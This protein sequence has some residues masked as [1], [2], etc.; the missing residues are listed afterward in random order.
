MQK[1]LHNFIASI[2]TILKQRKCTIGGMKEKKE[3]E[4]E[5]DLYTTIHNEKY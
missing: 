4:K 3:E 5:K 1:K 2:S